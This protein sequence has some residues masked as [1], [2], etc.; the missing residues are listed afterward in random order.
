MHYNI[1]SCR[2]RT[3]RMSITDPAMQTFDRDVPAVRGSYVPRPGCVFVSVD[4]DQIEARLT[5]HHSGDER[6]IADFWY[7]DQHKLKFFI[8]MA[9]RIYGERIT[10]RDPR[11]TWT[12]NATYGQIYGA[13]L[14]RAAVTAGVPVETM[15]PAYEG[16]A[17]MYPGVKRLMDRMIAEN[18]DRR[19]RVQ[20]IDGRWLYAYRGKEYAILNTE[21]QGDAAVI[22]KRGLVGLD[23]AGLGEFL[24]LPVHDEYLL[25]VPVNMAEDVLRE[26]ERI[27]TDRTN[28]RVPITWSGNILTERWV[29]TLWIVGG[30]GAGQDA[31]EREGTSRTGSGL[32]QL[33]L[34]A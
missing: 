16:L 23:A 29:K 10:K 30:V 32:G 11:Y 31:V 18:R 19:P 14:E 2:A 28:F 12:K 9:S 5:A 27:L 25:E 7:Y 24:R 8:E 13:G 1:H 22:M 26:A 21:I 6:M 17:Q 34:T 33:C 3:S 20:L 15:R 4:A